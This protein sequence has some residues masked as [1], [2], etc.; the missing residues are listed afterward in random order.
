M[1]CDLAYLCGVIGRLAGK[2]ID[3]N[4]DGSVVIDVGGVGY[5]VFV[6]NGALG[7]LAGG[8]TSTLYVHTH[9]REDSLTLF[10]FVDAD[11]KR[12]FRSLVSVNGIG[13]KLALSILSNL[14]AQELAHAVQS[15]DR[16]TFK[17]ISGVGKKTVERIILDL[18][19]KLV[20]SPGSAPINKRK[21]KPT[22]NLSS[23]P[24]VW[25]L[26]SM[27]F[28]RNEAER[29]VDGVDPSG[30]SNEVVLREALNALG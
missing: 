27:G 6:P 25:A 14:N 8:E 21:A 5:E 15:E 23:D 29:A 22:G 17:G 7:R 24:V 19:D 16:A 18:K 1:A 12:A 11:D 9:A 13:P 4:L 28:K 30:K 10:G 26:V 3:Q 20:V 2:I